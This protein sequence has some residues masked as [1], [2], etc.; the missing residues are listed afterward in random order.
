M[1]SSKIGGIVPDGYAIWTDPTGERPPIEIDTAQCCHCQ[2]VIFVKPGSGG[3]T[4]LICVD[5]RWQEIPGMGCR[6]C[7]RHVC[8]RCYAD[9]RCVPFERRIEQM[10]RA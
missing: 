9:G 7:N 8:W 4:F 3:Q 10:E 6:L 1:R 5:G 2:A